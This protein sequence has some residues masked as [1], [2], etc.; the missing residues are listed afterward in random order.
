MGLDWMQYFTVQV[1][2]GSGCLF[3]PLDDSY[4]YVLTAKHVIEN[5]SDFTKIKITQYTGTEYKEVKVLEEPYSHPTKDAVIIK[6][7]KVDN[8]ELLFRAEVD[9]DN[10]KDWFL[11]GYPKE[12][13][14]SKILFRKNQITIMN[15]IDEGEIEAEV[16][17]YANQKKIE[18]QSGGGII[19]KEGDGYRLVGIQVEM[20]N[21]DEELS[22]I[23][24]ASLSIFDEI[25]EENKENL[26]YLLPP[27]F[28]S[29]DRLIDE[30]FPLKNFTVIE[31]K[32][33]LLKSE[34]N[35]IAKDICPSFP[36]KS[37]L[38]KYKN[39]L[40]SIDLDD[41]YITHKN[42]WIAFLE[43]MTIK[44]LHLP[45]KLCVND[46]DEIRR[47]CQLLLLD[48][49]EWTRDVEKIAKSDLSMLEKGGSVIISCTEDNSPTKVELKTNYIN[50]ICNV[51]KR[52]M[53]I[54]DSVG[55]FAE[56]LKIIHIY[57]FQKHII[58]NESV[59]ENINS[60]NVNEILVN[61]TKGII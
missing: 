47:K 57:K 7:E 58:E 44:Q 8:L 26:S 43:L 1:E 53:R 46:L 29:L 50:N 4:S 52:E 18:G 14:D 60:S 5:I 10:T 30:I 37:V 38:E 41:T 22:R 17:K 55:N 20:I 13:I 19:K 28:Q 11:C 21:D 49:K 3:Q 9:L 51:P 36:V 23:H 24:F 61:E 12:R 16:Y 42:L 54:D 25:I 34:L 48:T 27:Y 32:K 35:A 56:D 6:V 45:D 31:T 33:D 59:F 39:T 15:P 40:L 2:G